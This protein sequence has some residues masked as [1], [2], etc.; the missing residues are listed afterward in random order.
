MDF[1]LEWY[2][3]LQNC[4]WQANNL[5]LSMILHISVQKGRLRDL[6]PRGPCNIHVVRRVFLLYLVATLSP[7]QLFVETVGVNSS[8][9]RDKFRLSMLFVTN[10]LNR[11][12]FCGCVCLRHWETN[13]WRNL[14]SASTWSVYRNNKFRQVCHNG[15]K[16]HHSQGHLATFPETS[17]HSTMPHNWTFVFQTWYLS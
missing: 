4:W 13:T 7:G 8:F 10:K 3:M 9:K 11:R 1:Y 15:Y 12:V 17:F 14:Q 5:Y 16:S 2:L 6:E